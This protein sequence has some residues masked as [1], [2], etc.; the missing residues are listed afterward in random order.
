VLTP[1]TAAYF[2]F[3]QLEN[4]LIKLRKQAAGT[5]W[6]WAIVNGK[7]QLPN[8]DYTLVGNRN[9]VKFNRT[10]NEQD[11]VEILHFA[12][13]PIQNTFGWRQFKDIFNRTHYKRL[14]DT[15]ELAEDLAFSDKQIVLNDAS[16][17]PDPVPQSNIP[18]VLFIDGERVEYFRKEGNVLKQLRRGTLGTGIKDV[19]E[20]GTPVMEQGPE[21][22][23]PYMDET[24]I[25]EFTSDGTT[26][27]AELGFTLNENLPEQDQIEV[28]GAGRRLKKNA[29]SVFDRE[30]AQDSPEGDRTQAPEFTIQD[31]NLFVDEPL[32]ENTKITVIRKL[33]TRW[34][35]QGK[36]LRESET[37]ISEF[38]RARTTDLPR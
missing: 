13:A 5:P 33:G 29:I 7:L 4:G 21:N 14:R 36:S 1:E 19:Y 38:L 31:G 22:N 35:E 2:D 18:G 27:V 34:E 25:Q 32:P 26:V 3:R 28:F 8:V 10:F 16:S 15:Q 23:I 12:S 20:A 9:F 30:L 11:T 6:V 24:E 17:L 37:K